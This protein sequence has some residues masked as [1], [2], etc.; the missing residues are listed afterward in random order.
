MGIIPPP[1]IH[2]PYGGKIVTDVNLSDNDVLG[3]MKQALP[4]IGEIAGFALAQGQVGAMA[5]RGLDIPMPDPAALGSLDMTELVEAIDGIRNVRLVIARYGGKVDQEKLL[6]QFNAGV[7][8][9]GRFSRVL[10]DMQFAPGRIAVYAQE[11]NGG[12][13]L[14]MFDPKENALYAARIV[15]GVDVPKLF[16]WVMNMVKKV[17]PLMVPKSPEPGNESGDELEDESDSESEDEPEAAQEAAPVTSD[18]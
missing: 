3:V 14:G 17:Q 16:G 4:S 12:Y 11:N 15:G 18:L 7:A 13:V 2:I 10:S 8:K 5:G 9:T 6:A 1:A